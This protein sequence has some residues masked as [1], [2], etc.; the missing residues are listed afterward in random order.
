MPIERMQTLQVELDRFDISSER[1]SQQLRIDVAPGAPESTTLYVLDPVFLFDLAVGARSLLTAGARLTGG[2][3]R[4]PTIVGVSYPTED[5]A[6]VLALRARDLTPTDSPGD[7]PFDLPPL[8]FGGAEPFLDA[9]VDEVIP[10]VETR[11]PA[12]ADMPRALV[13]FSF[14]ALFGIYSLL[15]RPDTFAGYLLG[16]PS[17]WWHDRLA[18]TWEQ[19]YAS[20]HEDLAAGAFLFVGAD[21]EHPRGGEVWMNER[22]PAAVLEQLRQVD[23]LNELAT[24]LQ[25]RNY[26]SL[27]LDHVVLEGEFHL[28]APAAAMARGMLSVIHGATS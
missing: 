24:R 1:T 16:S 25:R 12:T 22:L 7:V 28:T 10:T 6:E 5:P 18:F 9:L 3:F 20:T 21:E 11:H 8:A 2:G 19:D 26:P 15:H 23:N 27:H 4:A 14:S 17:L 13:G